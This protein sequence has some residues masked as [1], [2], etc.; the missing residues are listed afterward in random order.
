MLVV[1]ARPD[2][3]TA[4]RG[5]G[6]PSLF[7]SL[8]TW[9]AGPDPRGK[10]ASAR[11]TWAR[12]AKAALKSRLVR[13]QQPPGTRIGSA[14]PLA[15]SGSDGSEAAPPHESTGLLCPVSP[16]AAGARAVVARAANV[17]FTWD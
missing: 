8:D 16:S 4:T 1:R 17:A 3:Q 15:C 10:S 12:G 11:W 13:E 7:P 5:A 9:M 6:G 2:E 14:A